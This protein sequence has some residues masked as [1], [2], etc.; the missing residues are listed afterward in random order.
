[1]AM[2][3]LKSLLP[4]NRKS[5]MGFR[6]AYLNLTF[7]NSVGQ[8]QGHAHFDSENLGNGDRLIVTIAVNHMDFSLAY[9]QL[10]LIFSL[11]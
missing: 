1:M 10:A 6:L 8:D 9:L 5:C 11:L 4:S 3:R 2:A 7:T